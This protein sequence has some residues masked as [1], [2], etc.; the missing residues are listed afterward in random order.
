M[1]EACGEAPRVAVTLL[2]GNHQHFVQERGD[3]GRGGECTWWKNASHVIEVLI[4]KG[5]GG[6]LHL[7]IVAVVPVALSL[8]LL[9][10]IPTVYNFLVH[11]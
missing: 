11:H 9:N 10:Q 2:G 5:Q 8:P 7:G 4:C 6:P 3:V 1:E